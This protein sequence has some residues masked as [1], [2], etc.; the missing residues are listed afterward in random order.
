MRQLFDTLEPNAIRVYTLDLTL[1]CSHIDS[2]AIHIWIHPKIHLRHIRIEAALYPKLF[3][4]NA[5]ESY[6]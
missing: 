5:Q 2:G 3:L 1:E 6:S 4:A